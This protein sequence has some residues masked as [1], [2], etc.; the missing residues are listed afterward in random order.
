MILIL[1]QNK[2]APHSD[3]KHGCCKCESQ[4]CGGEVRREETELGSGR[5]RGR[6]RHLSR[7][8]RR[9]CSAAHWRLPA[10]PRRPGT[11]SRPGRRPPPRCTC[12]R[13]AL[14][15]RAPALHHSLLYCP[16]KLLLMHVLPYGELQSEIKTRKLLHKMKR[17][18]LFLNNK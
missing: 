13:V 1:L 12:T 17:N 6:R 3:M 2:S 9:A 15:V 8:G 11:W 16:S 14:L 7:P 18:H 4:W 5:R 10:G